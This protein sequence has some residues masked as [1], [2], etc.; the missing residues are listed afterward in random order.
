MES[1]RRAIAAI[2]QIFESIT[3]IYHAHLGESSSWTYQRIDFPEVVPELL[4]FT[5]YESN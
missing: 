5:D 2:R 1:Y 3:P 4:Y